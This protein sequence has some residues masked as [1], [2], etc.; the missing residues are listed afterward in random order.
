MTV[1]TLLIHNASAAKTVQTTAVEAL[2]YSR[3]VNEIGVC[4]FV[5]AA[6]SPAVAY[7]GL[8]NEVVIQRDGV[9]DFAGITRWWEYA[10]SERRTL[11][12]RA[13]TAHSLLTR[14]CVAW[15]AATA[16]RSSF[17]AVAAETIAKTLVNYNAGA[18]ATV[19]NGRKRA[20][21]ITGL[22]VQADGATGTALTLNCE[23]A[24]LLETLQQVAAL[25][26]GDFDLVRTAAGA[27]NFRWYNGQLGT[28]RSATVFFS[29]ELG[30]M[31][32]PVLTFD[33]LGEAT[34]AVV[35]GDGEESARTI[36]IRTSADY[37]ATNDI[38]AFVNASGA[39][40]TSSAGDAAL[41]ERRRQHTFKFD[42]LQTPGCNYG[43]HYGLGDLVTAQYR[44]TDYGMQV[45]GVTVTREHYGAETVDVEL[46]RT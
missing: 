45:R 12:V 3:C 13:Q 20:G 8:N 4:E 36:A 7:V 14:R 31:G 16:N 37:A 30:N 29:T 34:V 42:V 6:N 15:A 38:E 1:H 24:P 19:V 10:E 26:G 5:L 21:A 35:G 2:S 11:T 22:T 32:N 25:G 23:W 9:V 44:G 28:D 17:S 40:S 33:H 18:S 43:T 27:W 39:D 46:V 41:A